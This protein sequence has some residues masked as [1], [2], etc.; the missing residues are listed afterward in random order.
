M[1]ASLFYLM[2][3]SG[4]CFLKKEPRCALGATPPPLFQSIPLSGFFRSEIQTYCTTRS[5][6]SVCDTNAIWGQSWPFSL[7]SVAN[8]SGNMLAIIHNVSHWVPL[9]VTRYMVFSFVL[10]FL[11]LR[12]LWVSSFCVF[13]QMCTEVTLCFCTWEWCLA[14]TWL[15]MFSPEFFPPLS[16]GDVKRFYVSVFYS[17]WF[18]TRIRQRVSVFFRWSFK[19]VHVTLHLFL[20]DTGGSLDS[21]QTAKQRTVLALR[22]FCNIFF[23]SVRPVN[24]I[25]LKL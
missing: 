8:I 20:R 17:R 23:F 15:Q 21:L 7:H 13:L 6:T 18:L 11:F 2:Q 3:G 10:F 9:G 16:L 14:L 5:I 12:R 24:V 22:F 19:S 1:S 25:K 4:A